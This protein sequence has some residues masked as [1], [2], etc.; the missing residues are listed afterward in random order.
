MQGNNLFVICIFSI[1]LNL[2]L[3]LS[4]I[5]TIASILHYFLFLF[6]YGFISIIPSDKSRIIAYQAQQLFI[7]R[8]ICNKKKFRL[9]KTEKLT[10]LTF[11]RKITN[12]IKYSFILSPKS[13]VKWHKIL[14]RLRWTYNNRTGRPTIPEEIEKAV[15][16]I[17][18]ETDWGYPKIKGELKK[19]GYKVSETTIKNVLKRYV[20]PT[21]AQR[22]S[23]G[24][25]LNFIRHYKN[26]I[27]A[28]D[29]FTVDTGLFKRFYVLFFKEVHT[30]KILFAAC[31]EHPSGEWVTQQARNLAWQIQDG[32]IKA[33]FLIRDQDDKYT[34]FFDNVFKTEGI[35]I[36]RTSKDAPVQ[37][38]YAERFV[39]SIREECL[40]K[41]IILNQT[42]L[43]KVLKEYINYFNSARPHQGIDN[44][45]PERHNQPYK[46]EPT[47]K[48]FYRNILGGIIKDYFRIPLAVTT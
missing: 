23:S 12:R 16:R 14:V 39:R 18:K 32:K 38:S 1:I 5:R 40:D 48:I 45:I 35:K 10:L 42:H 11:G 2:I 3:V 31:T 20:V 36:V 17:A 8:R 22:K 21:S 47:G 4:H 37:N 44:G 33:R 26:L 13:L 24:T 6:G 9:T 19:L 28:S 7:T 27:L 46:V 29:F 25:W 41:I 15:V 43:D 34:E 30:R